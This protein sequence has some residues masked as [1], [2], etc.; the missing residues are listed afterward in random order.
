MVINVQDRYGAMLSRQNYWS[1]KADET[2]HDHRI[3]ITGGRYNYVQVWE[4]L[5]LLAGHCPVFH[6][7]IRKNRGKLSGVL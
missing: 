2:Q 1:Q 5:Q 7:T 3:A 6:G 4:T